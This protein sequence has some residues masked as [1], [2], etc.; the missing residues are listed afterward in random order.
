MQQALQQVLGAGTQPNGQPGVFAPANFQLGQSV[1]LSQI[2]TAARSV[3][4]VTSVT[5]L[6][7]QPQG[8]NTI[9]YLAA[10]EIKLGSLQVA[11]M[12]NDPSLPN[13]G[14]LTLIMQGGK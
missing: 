3:A 14:Q 6:T 10:G 11:R 12:A 13:H 1:Y 7:F 5:A 9:Q 8:V 4:G 2:Y